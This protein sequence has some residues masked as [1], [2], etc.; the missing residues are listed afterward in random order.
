MFLRSFIYALLNHLINVINVP[1]IIEDS[2]SDFRIF[3]ANIIMITRFIDDCTIVRSVNPCSTGCIFSLIFD[4][5]VDSF[6]KL[7]ESLVHDS[8]RITS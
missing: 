4:Q 8:R 7:L 5:F 6:L 3:V 1:Y 2:I